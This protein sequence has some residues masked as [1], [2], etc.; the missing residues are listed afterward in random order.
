MKVSS[1][2][3]ALQE[4]A[5]IT[6]TASDVILADTSKL[7]STIEV[8]AQT[9]AVASTQAVQI[10]AYFRAESSQNASTVI[11]SGALKVS[12]GDF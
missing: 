2:P 1:T 12:L 9:L 4:I 8:A 7:E 3:V 6:N 10:I 11:R 5:D